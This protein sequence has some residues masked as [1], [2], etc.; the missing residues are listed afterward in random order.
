[1]RVNQ[2]V[3]FNTAKKCH[4]YSNSWTTVL[5]LLIAKATWDST[6]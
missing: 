4:I 6:T 3:T 5:H 1:M 2:I